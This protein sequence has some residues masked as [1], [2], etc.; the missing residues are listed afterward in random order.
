M[1]CQSCQTKLSP[2]DQTCPTCGRRVASVRDLGA[3][4]GNEDSKSF[5]LPPAQAMDDDSM[6]GTKPPKQAAGKPAAKGNHKRQKSRKERGKIRRQ[7]P[8]EPAPEPEAAS[9]FGLDPQDV[10]RLLID[11]PGLIEEGLEIYTEDGK[12]IGAGFPTAVGDIDLLARDDSGAWVVV[13]VAE[14]ERGKEIVGDLLQRIGW[15]RRHLGQSGEEVR[16][17]VLLDNLPD[18]LGYTAA[19]VADTVEFKLYQLALT[20][21]PVIF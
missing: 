21:E 5:P 11:Q 19:A 4:S 20:F 18:D 17:I 12:S 13:A 1:Y 15:V 14:P 10:L 16:G 8:S 2:R 6:S 9:G 7:A 3:A